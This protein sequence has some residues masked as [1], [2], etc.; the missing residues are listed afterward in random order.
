MD[1][2]EASKSAIFCLN[3]RKVGLEGSSVGQWWLEMIDKT[4]G[5]G[6]TF[7]RVGSRQL[8]GLLTAGELMLVGYFG[9]TLLDTQKEASYV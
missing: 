3:L 7:E 6:L 5:E 4:L 2:H 1:E 9:L 8:E